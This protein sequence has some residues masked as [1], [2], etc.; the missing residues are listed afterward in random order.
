MFLKQQYKDAVKQAKLI[1]KD[2]ASAENH[3][4]LERAYFLRAQQL[5]RAGMEGSAI[6]VSRHLLEFGVT[7]AQ[8][9]EDL[10]PLLLK[11]CMEQDAYRIGGQP[12]APDPN[13]RLFQLAA[14]QAVLHPDRA[15]PPSPEAGQ[16]AALVRQA[17]ERLHSGDESKALALVHEIARGSPLSEWKLFL[18]GLAAFYRR[19]EAESEANWSRLDP[20]RAPSHIA[21]RL[22]TLVHD[23]QTSSTG[24]EDIDG[25]E[26]LVFGERILPSLKELSD[27]I[28]KNRWVD[29]LRR[30][31]PL[32]TKLRAVDP[33]LAERLTRALIAPLLEHVMDLDYLTGAL[34]VKE[35]ASVAEP[36]AMD[37]SWNRLWGLAREGPQGDP[38][39]AIPHWEGYARDL[40]SV[41]ALKDEERPLAE[42][43]VWKHIAELH[44]E[45]L[46]ELSDDDFDD[47]DVEEAPEQDAGSL[48]RK[49]IDCIERSLQLAPRHRP[50]YDL[51][52]EARQQLNEP[53]EVQ[54]VR[55]RIVAA[56]PEDVDSL[57]DLAMDHQRRNE[58]S[59]ALDYMLRARKQKPLD[60]SLIDLEVAIRSSLARSLALAKRWDEGR[61]Q[62]AAVEQL[63]P[64][65]LGC[66]VYLAKKA[67]FE[68]KAGQREPADRLEQEALCLLAEPTPLWLVYRVESIRYKLT[69]ATQDHYK[70]LWK[71]ALR[72][73]SRSD[74]AAAM[75]SYLSALTAA[76]VDYAGQD[77]DAR[78]LLAYLERTCRLRYSRDDLEQVCI[79]LGQVP[80][81]LSLT[82]K[83]V[84][85]GVKDK[86]DFAMLHMLAAQ[87]EYQ[88]DRFSFRPAEM[89]KHLEIALKLAEASTR[90]IDV[91]LL[92]AIKQL[93]SVLNEVA[94]RTI[95][96]P[97]F[98]GAGGS[99]VG[100]AAPAA[101]RS[102]FDW[103]VDDEDEDE[104]EATRS[105]PDFGSAFRSGRGHR[106]Q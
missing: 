31:G 4:L 24:R 88:S 34:R 81:S 36:C 54:A 69:K 105:S 56:F 92:P 65:Q 75:A 89:R 47:F 42:A 50:T 86:L 10:P 27:L 93:L 100:Q 37:P 23:H 15:Q 40:R 25:L 51:L 49:A 9:L 19:D 1:Y 72:K 71:D 48:A 87:A 96:F 84:A 28:S 30:I 85:R 94:S 45:M 16:E 79:F 68:T 58:P 103:I 44:L 46:E 39:A 11:L 63:Q 3:R 20:Q 101:R 74:S 80:G 6:E 73:K 32:R 5:R 43:L 97:L 77:K 98:T 18:R 55:K 70:N 76:K 13:S 12:H 66:Y 53:E 8:V 35:F 67:I 17:L 14:D 104:N 99:P 38:P 90:R 83:L 22:R 106:R 59:V 62:F 21:A 2:D 52:I 61:A 82:R 91:E 102:M 57:V 29:A 64:K 41:A 60:E 78:D 7:D 26:V 33:R 95:W